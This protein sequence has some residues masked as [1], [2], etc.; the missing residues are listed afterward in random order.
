MFAG[1]SVGTLVYLF[2]HPY[3]YQS[4]ACLLVVYLLAT[5][6]SRHMTFLSILAFS[7]SFSFFVGYSRVHG[8]GLT[9]WLT[10]FIIDGCRKSSRRMRR[11][12]GRLR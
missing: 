4:V 12:E 2:I 10:G 11:G 8:K 5:V 9:S 1:W 3:Q 6:T 7:F